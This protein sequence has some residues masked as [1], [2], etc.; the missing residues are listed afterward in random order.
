MPT[1]PRETAS[2]AHAFEAAIGRPLVSV[3]EAAKLT[4][5]GRTW[6]E[7]EIRCG[8]IRSH[9]PGATGNYRI[10]C[11]DLAEWVTRVNP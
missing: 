5:L 3:S 1:V 7:R 11:T 9:R 10:R 8:S 6:I 4:G 2:L